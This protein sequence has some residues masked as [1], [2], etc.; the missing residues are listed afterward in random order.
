MHAGRQSAQNPVQ[1]Q[2][3]SIDPAQPGKFVEPVRDRIYLGKIFELN[4]ENIRQWIDI[5]ED[6]LPAGCITIP[7][8]LPESYQSRLLTRIVVYGQ[9]CLQDYE[10]S[11][12]LP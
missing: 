10:S 6:R 5:I 4:A 9:I 1:P 12:N 3:V 7:A 2:H 11:L 8:P